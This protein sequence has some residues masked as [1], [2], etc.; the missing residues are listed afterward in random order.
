MQ[1]AYDYPD[2]E[3]FKAAEASG[4]TQQSLFNELGLK[5]YRQ[6]KNLAAI[7]ETEEDAKL[8]MKEMVIEELNYMAKIFMN[9]LRKLNLTPEIKDL[10]YYVLESFTQGTALTLNSALNIDGTY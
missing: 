1:A 5:R 6:E 8:V 9:N 2:L 7:K 3:D 10:S 4:E